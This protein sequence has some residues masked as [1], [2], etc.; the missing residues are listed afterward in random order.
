VKT[1]QIHPMTSFPTSTST[2]LSDLKHRIQALEQQVSQLLQLT[3]TLAERISQLDCQVSPNQNLNH[4]LEG[5]VPQSELEPN[6]PD[7]LDL[8]ESENL[9]IA[10]QR[11]EDLKYYY[12]ENPW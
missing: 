1:Q 11:A 8:A 12:H 9:E 3:Q 2:T 6:K 5:F 7:A 10:Y 4:H